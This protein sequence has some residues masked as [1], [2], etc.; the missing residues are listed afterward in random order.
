MQDGLPP[1]LVTDVA[2][3]PSDPSTVYAATYR[4][5]IVR[6]TDR[7]LS[8]TPFNTGLSAG[9]VTSL[10]IDSTGKFLVAGTAGGVFTFEVASKLPLELGTERLPADSSRLSRLLDQ[11]QQH[12]AS[13]SG[14]VIVATGNVSGVGGARFRSD[15]SLVN[16]GQTN[17]D[18][19]VAWLAAGSNGSS[20]PA[21]RITLPGSHTTTLSGFVDSLG[22]SGLGCLVVIAI[23]ANGNVDSRASIDGSSRMWMTG[24][25]N[26]GTVSQ[27]IPGM[28]IKDLGNRTTSSATGLRNDSEFRT[29]VGVVNLDMSSR[30]FSVD[31]IGERYSTTASIEVPPL[32]MRQVAVPTGDYGAL[33][34]VFRTSSGDFLWTAYGSSVNNLTGEGSFV[35]GK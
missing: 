4:S 21:F 15:V 7:G 18:V 26:P 25:N 13:S 34:A 31:L 12:G 23:D 33:Q 8:W 32:S 24:S 5:G 11:L 10:S 14:L 17:Q 27:S 9:G 1:Q 28:P 35:I 29:N 30:T 16:G 6:S 19:M 22:L 3:D 20:A 2:I